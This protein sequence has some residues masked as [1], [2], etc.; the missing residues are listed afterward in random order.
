MVVAVM[1]L[2]LLLMMMMMITE[3]CIWDSEMGYKVHLN[4]I[5]HSTSLHIFIS[6]LSH[7]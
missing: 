3:A 6:H 1:L 5:L 4:S 7:A 2:L